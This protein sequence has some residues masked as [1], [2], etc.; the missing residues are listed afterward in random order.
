M[1]T[2][3]KNADQKPSVLET[4]LSKEFRYLEEFIRPKCI[5]YRSSNATYETKDAQTKK[6]CNRDRLGME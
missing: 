1:G 2:V 6:D 5:K 3:K 4:D